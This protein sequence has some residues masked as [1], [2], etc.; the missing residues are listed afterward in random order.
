MENYMASSDNN[1]SQ[2]VVTL[3]N[4]SLT[5]MGVYMLFDEI[6]EQSSKTTCDFLLKA[7]LLFPS[8]NTITIFINSPGGSVTDGWAII[9][10]METSHVGI[11][12]VGI[13]EIASMGALIFVAGNKGKRILS[14]NSY[15]MTHQFAGYLYGKAH[16][17][18]AARKFHDKL[19]AQ[20]I[21]HF[22]KHTNMTEKQVRD[23]LLRESDTWLEPKEALKF[24]MC[25]IVSDPW[26]ELLGPKKQA[27]KTTNKKT[28]K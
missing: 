7:N 20:F 16:E 4:V 23:I 5:S 26:K 14:R 24:G 3:D 19:E 12:T 21:R 8:D 18:V 25:D 10:V 15:M 11:Q 2:Q 22:V 9:D 6:D 17:M 1:E 13:G 27:A 28:S